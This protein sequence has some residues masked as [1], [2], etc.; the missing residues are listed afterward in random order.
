ML[1]ANDY[2]DYY[3]YDGMQHNLSLRSG[4]HKRLV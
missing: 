3:P 4:Q 2:N 1:Y